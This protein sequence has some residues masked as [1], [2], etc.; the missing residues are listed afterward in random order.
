[1]VETRI[2]DYL[3]YF[4]DPANRDFDVWHAQD[5][6]SGNALAT[7]RKRGVIPGFARTVHHVDTFEDAR[8]CALQQ[9]SIAAADALLVVSR[10][11]GDWLAREHG[12]QAIEVGNGVEDPRAL[13]VQE[14]LPPPG[15][16]KLWQQRE[17]PRWPP[18]PVQTVG[19]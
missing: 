17:E 2:A 7:L 12:R 13:V 11:W 4:E 3:R 1:M 14:M 15:G 5:G 8:L 16:Y 6:I 9:R 19:A 18:L 10:L